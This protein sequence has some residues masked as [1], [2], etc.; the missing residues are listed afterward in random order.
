MSK[1]LISIPDELAFR[2]RAII[3]VRQ[4]SKIIAFLIEKEINKREQALY[5]CAVAVEKDEALNKEME[6]WDSTAGDGLNDE[7]W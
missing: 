4:R 6:D 7:T 1:V 5:D 3:P 2:M